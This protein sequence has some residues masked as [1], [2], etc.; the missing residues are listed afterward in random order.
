MEKLAQWIEKILMGVGVEEGMAPYLRLLILLTIMGILAWAFFKF[1]RWIVKGPV[2]RYVRRS[3]ATWDDLL[4][5]NNVF[6]SLAHIVPVI[7]VRVVAPILFQDFEGLLP[8]IGKLTEIYTIVVILMIINAL[9]RVMEQAL[10]KNKAFSDKPVASYVQL[11]RIILYIAAGILILSILMGK[12]PTY[13]LTAFGAMTALIM[14]IF[15]DTIL[16]LVASVQMSANDM[17]RIGD[18]VEMPKFNADGD[19]IAINLNTVKVQNWDKTVTSIPTYY[20]ITDSFKNWRG[21]KESGGRRI[22]R[23]LFINAAS[24]KFVDPDM[25]ERFLSYQL[26]EDYLVSRQKEIDAF[27]KKQ[28]VDTSVLINGRRMTNIGVFRHYVENYLRNH[29]DIRKDMSLMVRQLSI[30]DRGVPIEIYCFTKTTV[31]TEYEEIQS[32]IFDHLMA[33][34]RFLTWRFFSSPAGQI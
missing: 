31:W 19:V 18:W 7:I 10:L 26:L 9:L 3:K 11:I 34:Y 8:F 23:A 22:K 33:V 16:G 5:D 4:M 25:R 30:E 32:D 14:L 24:I 27:N 2:L 6:T 1:T 12:S 17:V 15:K 13:F 29:K 28:K 20:F 21:M